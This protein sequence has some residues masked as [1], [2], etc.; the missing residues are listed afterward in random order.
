M[1]R[2]QNVLH[3]DKVIEIILGLILLFKG[4]TVFGA[5]LLTF[6]LITFNINLG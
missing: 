6:G 2:E 3:I 5:T 4:Q 1:M